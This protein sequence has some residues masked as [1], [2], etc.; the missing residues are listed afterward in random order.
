MV[1]FTVLILIDSMNF[2]EQNDKTALASSFLT[3]PT[4]RQQILALFT[5]GN[6][7]GVRLSRPHL[8]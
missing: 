2:K 1:S 6:S 8:E 3:Q 4:C 7:L 5:F